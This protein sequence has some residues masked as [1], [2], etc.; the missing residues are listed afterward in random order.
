MRGE[1]RGAVLAVT[2][3]AVVLVGAFLIGAPTGNAPLDPR[4]HR[5]SGT[6]GLIALLRELGASVDL[7]AGVPDGDDVDVGLVLRDRFDEGQRDEL[8]RW[9]RQGGVL[10]V[11]DP[12]SPL[13]PGVSPA[14]RFDQDGD[15]DI[16]DQDVN[17]PV[18]ELGDSEQ[19][20]VDIQI[21]LNAGTCDIGA[22]DDPDINWIDVYGGAVRY[23]VGS[24][25][26]SCYGDGGTAY[27]V[28]TQQDEGTIV[29]LGGSGIIINRTLDESDNAPVIAALLAPRDGTR[30]AVFDPTTPVSE[31]GD[32]TLWGL[33]PTGVYRGLAQLGIAFL[34]Y[35]AWRVRRLGKPVAEPQPV[36]VAG[37][38][39]VA[40]VGGLL[41]RAR[42]P[43]HAADVL[44]AD[45]RRDL[46]VQFGLPANAPPQTVAQVV[47]ERSSLDPTRLQAA[48]G[49][50]PVDNDRDLLAVAQLIEIVRKEAFDHVGS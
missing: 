22:V 43:Q 42:S 12:G 8:R 10:V 49:P 11:V 48:L 26:E 33:V 39:L 34:V 9:V 40:A 19:F 45:L 6:S 17:D 29:A 3:L 38:E 31:E 28:A 7:D 14:D 47:G 25:A 35:V 37:S 41:E 4:S 46:G 23:Q 16:D 15:G 18:D 21:P 13:V 2:V 30:V 24:Q 32:E 20:G 36:K 5:P 1:G 44:R 50:G 27:I